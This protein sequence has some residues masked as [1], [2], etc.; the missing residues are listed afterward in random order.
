MRLEVGIIDQVGGGHG[1]ILLER[2]DGTAS[3]FA[4]F[5]RPERGP[6]HGR[7]DRLTKPCFEQ[8]TSLSQHPNCLL[9]PDRIEF[10]HDRPALQIAIGQDRPRPQNRLEHHV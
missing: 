1:L 5:V 7:H 10:G 6:N 9:E 4:P 8:H 3:K 2:G